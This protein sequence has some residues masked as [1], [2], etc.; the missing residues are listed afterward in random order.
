[1]LFPGAAL[2]LAVLAEAP[3]APAEDPKVAYLGLCLNKGQPATMCACEADEIAKAVTPLQFS[4]WV[5][6]TGRILAGA[7]ADQA[8]AM[9]D[10]MVAKYGLSSKKEVGAALTAGQAAAEAANKTCS[11]PL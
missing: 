8:A 4:I 5:D 11:A 1:M 3:S 7:G 9:V 6:V 10:D 2:A